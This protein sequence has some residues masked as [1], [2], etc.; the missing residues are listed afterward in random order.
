MFAQLSEC[1]FTI[2]AGLNN[3]SFLHNLARETPDLTVNLNVHLTPNVKNFHLSLNNNC[4]YLLVFQKIDFTT[5]TQKNT[6]KGK[7]LTKHLKLVHL[8]IA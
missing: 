2:S 4:R 5:W 3:V 8:V 6:G 1:H 7:F